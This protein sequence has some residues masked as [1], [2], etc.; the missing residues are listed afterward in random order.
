[1]Q[2]RLGAAF[3]V[4]ITLV[5][6]LVVLG[7]APPEAGAARMC[8]PVT[9][10]DLFPEP[11]RPSPDPSPGTTTTIVQPGGPTTTT[12][13][14]TTTTTSTETSTTTVP[15]ETTVT[16]EPGGD[17]GSSTVPGTTPAPQP[18]P[19]PKCAP[20]VYTMRW[21]LAGEGQNVSGFGAD[22]DGGARH[23]KGNDIAAPRLTP[24]VAVADGVVMSVTQEVGT[25]NCCWLALRHDDGWQSYYVHLNNDRWGTDDGMGYG[26]R[27][28]LV[29]GSEVA[30]GEVLGWVGDSGNAEETIDHLHFELRTPSGE[31]VD[32]RPSLNAARRRADLLDPQ[33][34][35]PYADDDGLPA[36]TLAATMLTEGLYLPCGETMV[37]FCPDE[38]AAPDLAIQIVSRLIGRTPPP[39]EGRYQSLPSPFDPDLV[40]APVLEEA[41]GC[42]PIED[43]LDFGIPETELARVAAWV[44]LDAAYTAS[45]PHEQVL[46]GFPSVPLPSSEAAEERLRQDGVIEECNIPLDD[47]RLLSRQETLLLLVSWVDGVNPEPCLLPGQRVS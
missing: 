1:M 42:A 45:L 33:P 28:D 35:W 18:K 43:C 5:A 15:E 20:F 3:V 40:A 22:R 24:V 39:V 29:E 11:S 36:E 19:K 30:A 2:G 32:P 23:H 7:A 14:T 13:V 25:E 21:P 6:A 26:V 16:T 41:M 38:V 10:D 4:T 9:L 27:P 8:P 34:F 17:P 12:V 47:E 37:D 44:A 46:E 31:A